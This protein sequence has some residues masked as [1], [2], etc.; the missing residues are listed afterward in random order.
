[1]E[2]NEKDIIRIII[3]LDQK[4]RSWKD[5]VKIHVVITA[6]QTQF[7][8]DHISDVERIAIKKILD[9]Y[10]LSK[11]RKSLDSTNFYYSLIINIKT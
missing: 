3:G 7:N 6:L 11:K 5:K 10:L 8:I 2:I 1:M 9:T 4:C